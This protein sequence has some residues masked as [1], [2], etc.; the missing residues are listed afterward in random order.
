MIAGGRFSSPASAIRLR[1]AARAF[2]MSAL[3]RAA[4]PTDVTEDIT[5]GEAADARW[6]EA[7]LGSANGAPPVQKAL[8]VA[9]RRSAAVVPA[10]GLVCSDWF[11]ARFG[12]MIEH[13]YY[14]V[15]PE[16]LGEDVIFTPGPQSAAPLLQSAAAEVLNGI[17][18]DPDALRSVDQ[19]ELPH[20][21]LTDGTCG[22]IYAPYDTQS[23][24][25]R[26]L[27]KFG[28]LSKQHGYFTEQ[29]VCVLT[30]ALGSERAVHIYI[31]RPLCLIRALP[32]L[33][34]VVSQRADVA[35]FAYRCIRSAMAHGDWHLTHI[36]LRDLH[37]GMSALSKREK[38]VVT[39]KLEQQSFSELNE[40]IVQLQGATLFTLVEVWRSSIDQ[41]TGWQKL[42]AKGA[43]PGQ[44]PGRALHILRL[45]GDALHFS[46]RLGGGGCV[47]SEADSVACPGPIICAAAANA[48]MCIA[49]EAAPLATTLRL[50]PGLRDALLHRIPEV[51]GDSVI[52][53]LRRKG[54]VQECADQM[55]KVL[56]A[57]VAQLAAGMPYAP[58]FNRKAGDVADKLHAIFY[59]K[60]PVLKM[61][62]FGHFA[63]RSAREHAAHCEHM[64]TSPLHAQA[65]KLGCAAKVEASPA[66]QALRAANPTLTDNAVLIQLGFAQTRADRSKAWEAACA[67]RPPPDHAKLAGFLFQ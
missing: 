32:H 56:K 64:R 18:Q 51:R 15:L 21:K 3:K 41:Q 20:A 14:R 29:T 52:A 39:K 67:A 37:G 55:P 45:P 13:R 60:N 34:P 12:Q 7:A 49:H 26:A 6:F 1:F 10:E 62:A 47:F 65:S 42:A 35:A 59:A 2:A 46:A 38:D 25:S 66:A 23:V 63:S 27:K 61:M 44:V 33:H 48:H 40:T 22:R 58:P 54:T 53:L 16:Q 24:F 9:T 43:A 50:T 4:S 19:K 17:V 11:W 30:P 28:E 57:W 36:D 31:P 8:C 5:N